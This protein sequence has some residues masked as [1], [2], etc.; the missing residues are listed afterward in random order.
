M[1]HTHISLF[2]KRDHASL[3]AVIADLSEL[4]DKL[5]LGATATWCYIDSDGDLVVKY[6][7]C[8]ASIK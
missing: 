3:P 4:N 2:Q 8:V 7:T 1:E 5:I 6:Y